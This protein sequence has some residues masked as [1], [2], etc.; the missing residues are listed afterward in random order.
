MQTAWILLKRTAA[1]WWGA[2]TSRYAAALAFY[3]LFSLG[4]IILLAVGISSLFFVPA[5]AEADITEDAWELAGRQG[6]FVVKQIIDASNGLGK[7]AWTITV[8]VATF[9]FGASVIFGE[10]QAALNTIW[11]VQPKKEGMILYVVMNRVRS[12]AIALVVGLLFVLTLL[13]STVIGGLQIHSGRYL[14]GIPWLWQCANGAVSFVVVIVLFAMIYNYLPDV[15]LGWRDVWMGA[16]VTGVLFAAGKFG[17]GF[18]LGHTSVAGSFGT[19]GSLAVLLVWV[20]Y[21]AMICFFG[22][23]FTKVYADWRGKEIAPEQHATRT[24]RKPVQP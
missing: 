23:E 11:Q 15:R 1:A 12:F 2:N 4:P 6:A 21:S 5:T 22:A 10:L 3:T 19:A 7:S 16:L 24:G 9:L 8:G 17:I 14:G 20:Y 18:Y 13:A